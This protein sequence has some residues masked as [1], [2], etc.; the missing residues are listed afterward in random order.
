MFDN[1][2]DFRKFIIVIKAS[3][4]NESIWGR[5]GWHSRVPARLNR[6]E[7]ICNPP[8]MCQMSVPGLPFTRGQYPT[9][10]TLH[11]EVSLGVLDKAMP[12]VLV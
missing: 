11:L 4:L 12:I 10:T 1:D 9:L 8:P 2:H 7:N 5:S 3:L 6:L